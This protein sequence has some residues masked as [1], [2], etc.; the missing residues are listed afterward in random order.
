MTFVAPAAV[1]A[2]RAR[3]TAPSFSV[4]IAAYQVADCI[5]EAVESA[6]AQTTP[7]QEVII[8]DDGSTDELGRALAPF[9]DRIVLIRQE[10]RG[11]AA[12]KNVAAR[13]ARGE[14]VVILDADDVYMPDRLE[15]LGQLAVERPDLDIL[16]TDAYLE[17]QGRIVRNVYTSSWPFVTAHQ[18]REILE[19]N[20]V[21]GLAAVRR[22]TLLRA[23][24]FDESIKRTTDWDCWIRLILDGSS[25]GAVLEPLARY[26]VRETSLSSDRALMIEGSI[27]TL[28]KACEHPQIL[29]EERIMAERSIFDLE[30]RLSLVR[31]RDMLSESRRGTRRRAAAIAL[32]RSASVSTRLKAG[33][34]AIVPALAGRYLKSRQGRGWVG[35]GGTSVDR[36]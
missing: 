1:S 8:C 28:R 19:R 15:A 30:Q 34:A 11:E 16:T 4:L 10:N 2:V 13:A 35:A 23:G 5:G 7:P 32:A 26:R 9:E 3:S 27:Q 31:L 14:F 29:L 33:A 24:G 6:L 25:V 21:F 20:F 36:V 18:R 17:S 22:E 12:A